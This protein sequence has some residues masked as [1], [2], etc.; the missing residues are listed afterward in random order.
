ALFAAVDELDAAIRELRVVIFGLTVSNE[1]AGG[2][3]AQVLA[4]VK[5]SERGLGF[6]PGVRFDGVLDA[7]TPGP[8]VVET[9][10]AVR[11]M[12]SNVARHA[13]ATRAELTLQIVDD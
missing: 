7:S 12:L 1:T 3:R 2:L 5:E 6:A 8:L 9:T 13:A 4:V 11:E 10:A